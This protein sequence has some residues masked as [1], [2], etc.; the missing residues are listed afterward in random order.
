MSNTLQN[1]ID[2]IKT[3]EDIDNINEKLGVEELTVDYFRKQYIGDNNDNLV[4]GT[5]QNEFFEGLNGQDTIYAGAG[6]DLIVSGNGDDT[7]TA[8][9]GFDYIDG[10]DG[11]DRVIYAQ[12][13]SGIIVNLSENLV[14][15]DGEGSQDLIY[16]VE[17]IIGSN[18]SDSITGD[19][20]NNIFF[21]KGGNDLSYG[22]N[23][24][25]RIFGQNGDD[26]IYGEDGNDVL[27][28]DSGNNYLDG[29]LGI[30]R[31]VYYSAKSG[32]IVNLGTG[33]A[34]DNG[35]SGTDILVSIE[36]VAGSDF[37][38]VIT[39]NA[40]NNRIWLRDGDDT[41][42]GGDG[43]DRLFGQTGN[44]TL[45]GEDGVDRIFGNSGRDVL[46]GGNDN[47]Y[48]L[49]GQGNDTLFGEDGD[50]ILRGDEGNNILDG[51]L[52][53][54]RAVYYKASSKVHVDLS[55]GVAFD[56][57]SGGKDT[58]VNIENIVG[59]VHD[60]LIV[61]DS[62]TNI[63]W[64]R[65]GDDTAYGGDGDDKL[66]GQAGNDTIYG[67]NGRDRIFGHVGDDI[68]H[69]G[70]DR[71]YLLG[72]DGNDTLYGENGDDI[73]R[74]GNDDNVLDGGLGIDRA[75][76]FSATSGVVVDLASGVA[77]DNGHGG[78]DVLI[79]IEDIVGSK[80]DDIINGDA[81]NN[82]LWLRDGDDTA[83]GAGGNNRID[84]G[85]GFDTINYSTALS[86]I[87]VDLAAGSA[88]QNGNGGI[89][90]LINIES[91]IGSTFS[92]TISGSSGSD[93]IYASS[94]NDT[95]IA[96]IGADTIDGGAGSD[97]LDYS[98]I[99]S[100]GISV[101][102]QGASSTV[103]SVAGGSSDTI[104][105]IENIIGTDFSDIIVGDSN[106]NILAGAAGDDTLISGAGNNTIDGG[107]GTDFLDYS[108]AL[109]GIVVDMDTG[110]VID[111]GNG[112]A[113]IYTN[114]EGIIA[115]DFN[116]TINGSS[117]N[118]YIVATAGDDIIDGGDGIDTLSF[119]NA[120]QGLKIYGSY[121]LNTGFG[122]KDTISNIE[123]FEGSQFDDY[124]L[125]AD[126]DSTIYGLDGNDTLV[127]SLYSDDILYGG[128]GSDSLI[129]QGGDNY[130]YGGNGDDHLSSQTLY[131]EGTSYMYGEDGNDTLISDNATGTMNGGDGDDLYVFFEYNSDNNADI[132][133]GFNNT[134]GDTDTLDIS[135]LLEDYD[136]LT[137]DIADFCE[138]TY[139]GEGVTSVYVNEDGQG[140]D[141]VLVSTI[142]ETTSLDGVSASDLLDDGRLIV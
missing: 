10:G 11:I 124:I 118:D 35:H 92:D 41:A 109:S 25:D 21:L 104:S 127:G 29:G 14:D 12:A 125:P 13:T 87:V 74:G 45:F 48:L 120:T 66:Y 59:S 136:E 37:N 5:N 133:E 18:Y 98:N 108:S 126:G 112:G 56:N 111:N 40:A 9:A 38:D 32:V 97:T 100:G 139:E 50:D 95:I 22:G 60:D 123:I 131:G 76:Y 80:F 107:A 42:Y 71:D 94:G 69:G 68:L 55:S 54:D 75:V 70:D 110:L 52:G 77:S 99:T 36:D 1:H 96:T 117:S 85:E 7:I 73:L 137:S 27:R 135:Y 65:D 17:N 142:T 81:N 138:L 51:G 88:S 31:A 119:A 30:D 122:D 115:T 128:D 79:N 93:S 2:F 134:T 61:G 101:T 90:T 86:G 15:D 20:Q 43:D 53:I 89:D 57:G 141:W 39:G 44:D 34:S 58:L 105:S 140:D 130:L 103:I 113:D 64:L 116:D 28:G 82:R 47:D 106:D 132:I 62:G 72:G 83:Y 8:G 84:G 24:N 114:I 49:G 46:Y 16:N 129:A 3:H 26:T 63:F 19:D 121:I 33:T 4:S 102:L 91:V 67:E 23:G 6:N 78:F